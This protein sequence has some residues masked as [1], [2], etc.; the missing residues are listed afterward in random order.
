MSTFITKDMSTIEMAK[1]LL[2]KFGTELTWLTGSTN[3]TPEL[4]AM[5]SGQQ[6]VGG[7]LF[8]N[9]PKDKLKEFDRTMAGLFAFFWVLNEDYES[10]VKCQSKDKLTRATFQRL[11]DYTKSVVV[12]DYDVIAM[13]VYLVI[14]DL[15]KVSA[16]VEEMYRRTGVG[17]VDHDVLLFE[18]LSTSPEL[19]PSFMALS[20][21]YRGIMLNGLGTKFNFGHLH[22]AEG[23]AAI[24]SGL[25]SVDSKSL[26]FFL[27]HAIFDTAG[28]VG[29]VSQDGSL[30]LT[31]SGYTNLESGIR[32]I[33]LFRSSK[34]YELY[35]LA[36]D[37]GLLKV[38]RLLGRSKEHLAYLWM[39]VNRSKYWGL[40]V[41]G[42]QTHFAVARIACELR[43]RKNDRDKV[44]HILEAVEKLS[45]ED[46]EVFVTEMTASGVEASTAILIYYAPAII[47]NAE[48]FFK[49]ANYESPFN[50]AVGVA[51][52]A[53]VRILKLVRP[54]VGVNTGPGIH[55]AMC[56]QVAKQA[57]IDPMSLA[58]VTLTLEMVGKDSVVK[59]SR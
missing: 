25:A 40:D 55:K 33:E 37:V 1:A 15:T 50:A 44:A 38:M 14:N 26:D 2:A 22:Q 27:I 21:A 53:F 20:P 51:V 3:A 13:C 19:S 35:C 6:T 42:N 5:Q 45:Q 18:V 52:F 9:L 4:G 34:L 59:V 23:P 48:T 47:G 49:G 32:A 30:S 17:Q 36:S 58:T 28:V 31:E 54:V 57:G 7:Q 46:S 12:T 39:L 24:L 41:V 11:V 43:L 29:H 56:D 10:F 8:P 16:V